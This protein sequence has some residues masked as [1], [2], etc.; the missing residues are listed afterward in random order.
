MKATRWRRCMPLDTSIWSAK[1]KRLRNLSSGLLNGVASGGIFENSMERFG[2][3][4]IEQL[5]RELRFLD[6][7]AAETCLAF[8]L[9]FGTSKDQ[10]ESLRIVESQ[11]KQ[12]LIPGARCILGGIPPCLAS[13]RKLA[14]WRPGCWNLNG[15]HSGGDTL[16]ASSTMRG[17]RRGG[18]QTLRRQSEWNSMLGLLL[19]RCPA[20]GRR[21]YRYCERVF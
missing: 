6:D 11:V 9:A 21:R 3:G 1:R 19:D 8:T 16:R 14:T 12:E 10:A 5:V 17:I 4:E 18:S 7:P 20:L 2:K 13:P 15:N